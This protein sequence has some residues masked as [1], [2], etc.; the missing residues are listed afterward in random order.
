MRTISR[1]LAACV[2]VLS[3][4]AM[5]QAATVS[6]KIKW[7]NEEWIPVNLASEG[8]ELK[9]VRFEVQGG[10]HWNPLRAGS[11]P[12]AFVNVKN[13]SDHEM[14][15]AVAV[16]LFDGDGNLLGATEATHIGVLDP[17]ETGEMKLTF[18]EVKRKFFDAKTA[19]IA[20]ETWK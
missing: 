3:A 12:Q 15:L 9:D 14:R 4:V 6:K 16:A 20:L 11:G 18:R 7:A 10:I 8:I 5:L 1:I 17:G 19:Q 2:I 13:V